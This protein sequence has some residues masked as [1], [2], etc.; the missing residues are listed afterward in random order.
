MK[1]LMEFLE[2]RNGKL[3]SKRLAALVAL[4]ASTYILVVLTHSGQMDDSYFIAYVSFMGAVFGVS[5]M[6]KGNG[7]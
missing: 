2:D 5:V 4:I 1:R 3:S 7:S 6:E